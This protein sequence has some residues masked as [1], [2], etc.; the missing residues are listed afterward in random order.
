[1]N[2]PGQGAGNWT[3]KLTQGALTPEIGQRL[4]QLTSLY[5]RLADE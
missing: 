2:I 5:N 3:W 1:M 4:R